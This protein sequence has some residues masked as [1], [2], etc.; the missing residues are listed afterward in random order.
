M[1]LKEINERINYY[2]RPQTFPTAIRMC[3]SIEEVPSDALFPSRVLAHRVLACQAFTLARR[4][5][6]TVAVGKED[7]HCPYGAIMLGFSPATEAYL[8][9]DFTTGYLPTKEAAKKAAQT[10]PRLEYGKYSHLLAAPLDKANFEPQVILI[11]GDPAQIMR[12]IQGAIRGTGGFLTSSCMGAFLCGFIL[13]TMA[14]NECQYFIPGGGDRVAALV[15]D[16]ELCFAA[17]MSKIEKVVEGLKEG[18]EAH[19]T[20]YPIQPLMG[21]VAEPV[22]PPEY[23]VLWDY[24]E[25][26]D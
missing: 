15:Q 22:L 10:M 2:I 17:P 13:A 23:A 3:Q 24:L 7:H 1:D 6:W 5:G 25:K 20:D 11:Y 26:L 14:S 19:L 8:A 21:I 9:G 16:H 18:A 12:L 4:M